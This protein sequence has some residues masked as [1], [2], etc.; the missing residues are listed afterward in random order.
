VELWRECD[1]S[2]WDLEEGPNS[3]SVCR[4][5]GRQSHVIEVLPSDLETKW[6]R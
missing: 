5:C 6:S 4:M 1:T 2:A 3:S